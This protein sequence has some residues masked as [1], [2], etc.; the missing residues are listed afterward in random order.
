MRVLMGSLN[1]CCDVSCYPFHRDWR[2]YWTTWWS[3]TKC[4]IQREMV[5]EFSWHGIYLPVLIQF[6]QFSLKYSFISRTV[7]GFWLILY[8]RAEAKRLGLPST[9]MWNAKC[10]DD[11][12]QKVKFISGKVF[13]THTRGFTIK[14]KNSENCILTSLTHIRS[15]MPLHDLSLCIVETLQEKVVFFCLLSRS[16]SEVLSVIS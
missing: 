4:H 7:R 14:K 5:T 8:E 13:L 11:R 12:Y 16:L 3:P 2:E 15:L 9:H 1:K 10:Q 6:F